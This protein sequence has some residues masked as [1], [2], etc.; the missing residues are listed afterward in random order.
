LPWFIPLWI[1]QAFF[2]ESKDLFYIMLVGVFLSSLSQA[3]ITYLYAQNLQRAVTVGH[4]G[5]FALLVPA[6]FW[7]VPQFGA[8]A[9][10]WI[11]SVRILVDLIYLNTVLFIVTGR[12]EDANNLSI[13]TEDVS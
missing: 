6:L 9:A 2:E 12:A 7:L 1:S 4:V 8:T 10:A 13:M 11:W 5:Q 3:S